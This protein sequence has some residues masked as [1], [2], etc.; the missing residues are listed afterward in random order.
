MLNQKIGIETEYGNCNI[1]LREKYFLLVVYS[2]Q[3]VTL[4]R[5][6]IVTFLPDLA[7][8]V[9]F[10]Y[11][12]I[13]DDCFLFFLSHQLHWELANFLVSFGDPLCSAKVE[14]DKEAKLEG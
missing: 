11:E 8:Y 7:K 14:I 2:R 12:K 10:L 4:S 9:V 3:S 13:L 1:S 5:L 6:A